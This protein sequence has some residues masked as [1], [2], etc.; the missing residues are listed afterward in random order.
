VDSSAWLG[1][2][3]A[4]LGGGAV[5]AVTFLATRN[6][7]KAET[8][9]L[10]AETARIEAETASLMVGNGRVSTEQSLIPG[11]KLHGSRPDE[12]S[13]TIDRTVAHSGSASALLEARLGARGFATLV[14]TVNALGMRG[15]RI[16]MS[17]YVRAEDVRWAALWM[18]VDGPEE[19]MLSFDNMGD[20]PI[21][22][23]HNW[24]RYE[25]VLDVDEAAHQVAFG[26]LLTERGRI[27]ADDFEFEEVG[28]DVATTDLL[29]GEPKPSQPYNLDFEH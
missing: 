21:Q 6:K 3:S 9:K 12:Y 29:K 7:T 22:G 10:E 1:L 20:R 16:K 8:R 4:L 11:W 14:Q 19:I 2:V 17:A 13:A 5:S 25:V 15:K 23:T 24:R 26:V 18:R 27:W 28:H